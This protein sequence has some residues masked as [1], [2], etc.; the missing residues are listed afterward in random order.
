M[1]IPILKELS[2]ITSSLSPCYSHHLS[3]DIFPQSS[4]VKGKVEGAVIQ[5]KLNIYASF[6]YLVKSKGYSGIDI[7]NDAS[8]LNLHFEQF[9]GFLHKESEVKRD[10]SYSLINPFRIAFSLLAKE[11]GLQLQKIKLSTNYITDDLHRCIDRYNALSIDNTKRDYLNGWRAVSKN[12]QEYELFLDPIYTGHGKEF[13]TLLHNALND[14]TSKMLQSSARTVVNNFNNLF[15]AMSI[16]CSKQKDI[17]DQLNH[18]NLHQF[19]LKI[20]NLLFAECLAKNNDP[21]HFFLTWKRSVEHFQKCFIQTGIFDPPIKPFVTPIWKSPKDSIFTSSIG[22]QASKI[23]KDRWFADIPLR[24]KDEEAL[25]II[26]SR[27]ERDLKHIHHICYTKFKEFKKIDK[28]NDLYRCSGVIKPLTRAYGSDVPVGDKHVAN[29]VATFHTYGIAGKKSGYVSFLGFAGNSRDLNYELNLPT[30]ASLAIMCNLLIQQHP[31]I[32]PS[33]LEKWELFNKNG[34]QT[35]FIQSGNQF[36]IDSVKRRRGLS[37]AQQPIILNEFSKEVVEYLIEHTA[38][39]RDNLR[40]KKDTSWRKMLLTANVNKASQSSR[41]TS[42][43]TS[44]TFI[45]WMTDKSLFSNEILITQEEAAVIA[46]MAS[47]R[48][49]RRNKALLTY[50]ET[51]S[52][53]AVAEALGHKEMNYTLLCSYLPKPLMDFFN[54]RWIRQFQNAILLEALKG[55]DYRLEAVDMTADEIDE[56]LENH[57]LSELPSFSQFE[58][59]STGSQNIYVD[60][61]DFDGATFTIGTA[62]LQVLIA[63]RNTIEENSYNELTDIINNWYESSIFILN[64]LESEQYSADKELTRML[65]EAKSN[66]LDTQQFKEMILCVQ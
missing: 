46:D 7:L 15:R 33:W 54:D 36:L 61:Y 65:H 4:I 62:L 38:I 29:T 49:V 55:S 34:D 28:R 2:Q 31:Q 52:M 21:K 64:L 59:A 19:F 8:A 66:P 27:V 23:E 35:G 44:P 16:V 24:I 41:L 57:A 25:T 40:N 11:R 39:A 43:D 17:N 48:S 30:V 6:C 53:T 42:Y 14:Y 26:Q 60:K 22:G 56:F 63:I 12:G 58:A 18:E 9:I 32:T 1:R 50:L 10:C 51:H 13:A 3:N 20:M 37:K 45:G 47:L 5:K